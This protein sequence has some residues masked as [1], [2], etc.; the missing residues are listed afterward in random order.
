MKTL[1][2]ATALVFITTPAL[3]NQS[4]H[5]TVTDHF[6]TVTHN[7]PQTETVCQMVQVPVYGGSGNVGN[8]IAGAIIGGAIGNQ[9]GNGSGRDA[10]TVLGAIVGADVANRSAQTNSVV[11]YRQERQCHEVT[12][13]VSRQERVYTHST[14]TWREGGRSFSVDFQR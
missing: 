10:M 9:F 13:Y 12:T 7:I 6:R 5:A 3:S 11:G 14:V 2:L 1:F 8:T 4:V